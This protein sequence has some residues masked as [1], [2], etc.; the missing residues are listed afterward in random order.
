M[1]YIHNAA[2]SLLLFPLFIYAVIA[3]LSMVAFYYAR[4]GVREVARI[5]PRKRPILRDKCDVMTF[6]S[7]W[8]E[9]RFVKQT[10]LKLGPKSKYYANSTRKGARIAQ[11]K[12]K[13]C[14][15][16]HSANAA[17]QNDKDD[18]SRIKNIKPC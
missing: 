15:F 2:V 10:K 14:I 16:R 12:I 5:V 1:F 17:S 6:T 13:P 3:M 9:R 11:K 4:R 8:T 18:R 7:W